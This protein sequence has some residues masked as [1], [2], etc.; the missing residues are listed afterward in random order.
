MTP[1][2]APRALALVGD[3]TGCTMW[4]VWQPFAALERAGAVAH[5]A[6]KDDPGITDPRFMNRVP[7]TYDVV[8]LPRLAWQDDG[9]G[10][11]F[12][13][14][15]HNVGLSVI[16]EV[17]DDVYSESI[18]QRQYA[19]HATER[20][21]G[22]EQLE[23]DRRARIHAVGLCDGVTV[24][25]RRLATIVRQY[26]DAPIEVVPNAIDGRWFRQTL[27]GCTRVVPPLTIGWAGGARYADDLAPLGVAW[28]RLARRYPAVRFVTQGFAPPELVGDLPDDRVT[29]LPWLPL[30]EYPRGLLNIDIGCASVAARPFNVAKTPIKVWEM[31]L[32]GAVV[33]GSPTLYGAVITDGEDGLI[34]ETADE[35]EAQLGRLVEDA[36]L[37]RAL[38][39][40]QRRRIAQQHSLEVNVMNW[41]RAWANIIAETRSRQ[42]LSQI[43][44]AAA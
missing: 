1:Q 18:V 36:D 26:T 37:R 8:I 13:S 2:E 15:L 4:R 25:S 43:V 10:E 40:A 35:W 32:A 16:Y 23:R 24:T 21:K 44:L 33:V 20:A 38:R 14:G 11:R 29:T 6:H 39:K 5:W 19:V 28:A 17:D 27:R 41:P 31:T 42:A 12:I 7:F 22:L 34:A 3:E 30:A 9:V